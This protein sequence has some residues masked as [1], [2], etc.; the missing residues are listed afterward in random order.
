MR[1]ARARL[2]SRETGDLNIRSPLPAA[3]RTMRDMAPRMSWCKWT[4]SCHCRSHRLRYRIPNGACQTRLVTFGTPAPRFLYAPSWLAHYDFAPPSFLVGSS[5]TRAQPGQGVAFSRHKA[6]VGSLFS[7]T[8]GLTNKN[9][10]RPKQGQ[11]ATEKINRETDVHLRQLAKK[12]TH[13]L[14]FFKCLFWAF[15]GKGSSKTREK[16]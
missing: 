14:F 8:S 16:N 9:G 13:V 5:A 3:R 2:E 4:V 10:P 1:Y 11:G 7:L 6:F 15:L 12:N